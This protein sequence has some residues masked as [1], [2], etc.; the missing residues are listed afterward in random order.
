M[1]FIKEIVEKENS[2]FEELIDCFEKI[3]VNG[4]VVVIKF[5]GEREI[6]NYTVFISFPDNKREMIRADENNLKKAL[7]KVLAKYIEGC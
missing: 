3:K 5:D 1:N 6:D 7:V 2:S 4:E